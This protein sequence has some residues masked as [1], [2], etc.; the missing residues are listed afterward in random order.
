MLV[1][2]SVV[3]QRYQAV[4]EVLNDGASVTDVA[5]RYGVARQT[6][7][8]W[9]RQVR[10]RGAAR[11]GRSELAAVVVPA[12]DGPGRSRRGIVEM[13]RAHPGWGPRTILFWLERE[14]VE[15][16]P[17]RTSVERCLIRH[18]LVT[19]Q[20][21][22]R[23]RSRLHP[24]GAV[25]GRWSCGRW[26]SSAASGSS[27]AARP[28]SCRASMTTRRFVVSAKVVARATARPVCDALEAAMRRPWGA[29][30]GPDRQRQGVH[31]PVRAG[32]GT[33]AASIGS[34]TTTGSHTCSPPRGRRPRRARSSVGTRRCDASS[35]TARSSPRSPT[36]RRGSTAGCATTTTSGPTSRSGGCHPSSGSSSPHPEPG[37]RRRPTSPKLPDVRSP[38][39]H[40]AGV[41]RKGTISFAT[42]QVPGGPC[43]WPVRASRSSARRARAAAP[44]RRARRHPR[45]TAS[46]RQAGTPGSQRGRRLAR[47]TDRRRRR[48]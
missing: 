43:G 9:L 24:L 19:P 47:T 2:L 48:R 31:R 32:T 25:A 30:G 10:G 16:L 23:K 46:P 3:E 45:S 12:S 11:V 20:A 41:E 42:A 8:D 22:K 1:E 21:R 26:T 33:G 37:P 6:V 35:S 39:D 44:P 7:H 17:G 14:G 29:R 5:R 40:A 4:L 15:P 28:R 36:P 38:S 18:G 34:A 27:T 13:R